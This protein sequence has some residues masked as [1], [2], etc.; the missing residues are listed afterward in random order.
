MRGLARVVLALL[1]GLLMA[2][3]GAPRSF[4]SITGNAYDAATLTQVDVSP[5]ASYSYDASTIARVHGH[6]VGAAQV[7][8]AQLKGSPQVSVSLLPQARGAS[9]TPLGPVVATNTA[10]RL[11]QD[12]NVNLTAPEPLPLNRPVGASPT[13]DASS[14]D[15]V[16]VIGVDEHV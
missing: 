16:R 12:I 11:S 4:A 8:P 2:I 7:S 10:A 1:A 9:T 3:S 6:E 14:C 13:Q 5:A 15:G